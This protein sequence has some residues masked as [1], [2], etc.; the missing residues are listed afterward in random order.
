MSPAP[1][2][3]LLPA[4]LLPVVQGVVDTGKLTA[5][6]HRQILQHS[7]GLHMLIKHAKPQVDAS[8]QQADI[9]LPEHLL[10]VLNVILRK[11]RSALT[12]QSTVPTVPWKSA[13]RPMEGMIK[14]GA[15]GPPHI[16][17][18][19]RHRFSNM[20]MTARGML[21]TMPRSQARKEKSFSRNLTHSLCVW[22]LHVR[23]TK[24]KRQR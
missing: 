18:S 10:Q 20:I 21:P 24:P 13:Q 14:T 17:H 22:G 6:A 8:I 7:L 4:K 19:G 5:A 11:S 3:K 23:S 16:P 1:E 9:H 15:F 12:G 2:L